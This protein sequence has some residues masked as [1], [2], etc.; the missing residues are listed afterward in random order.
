MGQIADQHS[1]CHSILWLV[2]P[3]KSWGLE[4]VSQKKIHWGVTNTLKLY[5]A[6][7]VLELKMVE[8]QESMRERFMYFGLF[9]HSSRVHTFSIDEKKD[10]GLDG[11]LVQYNTYT[12]SYRVAP[13][14]SELCDILPQV[15]CSLIPVPPYCWHLQ[16]DLDNQLDREPHSSL[17]QCWYY[18]PFYTERGAGIAQTAI[19]AL[20]NKFLQAIYTHIEAHKACD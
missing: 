2:I 13:V 19:N 18:L 16:Q 8:Y 3:G 4:Y 15:F 7:D 6:W 11:I 12:G 1:P 10:M 9:L 20:Q 5:L 17:Q 14:P